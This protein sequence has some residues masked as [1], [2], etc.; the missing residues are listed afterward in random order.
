MNYGD[1]T[2]AIQSYSEVDSNGLTSTTLA[3]IVQNA[4]NRI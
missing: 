1:L 2:T 3:T 4:E